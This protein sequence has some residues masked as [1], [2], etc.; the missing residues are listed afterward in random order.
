MMDNFRTQRYSSLFNLP[1]AGGY[2]F[3]EGDLTTHDLDEVV[4]DVDAVIHLAAITDATASLHNPDEVRTNNLTA[5]DRI[6]H[7]CA[8]SGAGLVALSTTSVYGPQESLV[9]EDCE[10]A[11]LAP[12]SPYAEVK[13]EE[14]DLLRDLHREEGLKVVIF[15]FGTIFG[16]SPGMRFHTA[17]NRFCWQA[18]MGLP[19]TV[20]TTAYDQKRPYLDLSD[21][22]RMLA[23]VVEREIFD[24]QTY[25]AVTENATVREIVEIIRTLVPDLTVEL[26]DSPVMNQL[27]YEVSRAR[28]EALGFAYSG[29]LESGIGETIAMLRGANSFGR[30]VE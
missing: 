3:I 14:E 20:W 15:R 11:D 12:Q 6:A 19:L 2:R 17:V 10:P 24:G 5:T 26:T 9:S 21:A 16:P 1:V 29:D 4:N 13:L 22:G 28:S 30:K 25:N 23:F 18:I 7:A 27:S 8:R